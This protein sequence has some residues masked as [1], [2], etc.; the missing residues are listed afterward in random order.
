MTAEPA[1]TKPQSEPEVI[2]TSGT[3]AAVCHF[4]PDGTPKSTPA[5]AVVK[6]DGVPVE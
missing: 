1:V 3:T 5:A 4:V 2:K 6:T